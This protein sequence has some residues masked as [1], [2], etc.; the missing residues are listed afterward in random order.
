MRDERPRLRGGSVRCSRTFV[1][2]CGSEWMR[3]S[4]PIANVAAHPG[5]DVRRFSLS[6]PQLVGVAPGISSSGMTV[7]RK[8]RPKIGARHSAT[9]RS[10]SSSTRRV[11][12][13]QRLASATILECGRIRHYQS[14][15]TSSSALSGARRTTAWSCLHQ[16]H[17]RVAAARALIALDRLETA[18]PDRSQEKRP[19]DHRQR[20]GRC[21]AIAALLLGATPSSTRPPARHSRGRG[22]CP[23]LRDPRGG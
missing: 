13:A 2:P 20:A 16:P 6:P 19:A 17:L 4:R 14:S 1:D 23:N 12:H 9:E 11:R 5:P 10:G 22:T 15:R 8:Q 21:P 7:N 3:F 18:G